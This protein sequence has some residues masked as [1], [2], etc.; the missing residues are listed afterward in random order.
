M[1]NNCFIWAHWQHIRM[2]CEWDR[3]GQP[4]PWEPA[5]TRRPSRRFTRLVGH[6]K[7]SW[8]HAHTGERRDVRGFVP[9]HPVDVPWYLAWTRLL[10]RG[11]VK[12]GDAPSIPPDIDR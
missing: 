2:C 10:F 12:H 4:G 5:I 9:I 1:L 8:E 11:R 3:A 7:V 6:W